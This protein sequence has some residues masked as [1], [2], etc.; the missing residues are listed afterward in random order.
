M[1]GDFQLH[2]GRKREHASHVHSRARG[3]IDTRVRIAKNRRTITHAV[4]NIGIVVQVGHTRAAPLFH[5]NGATFSPE[6]EV[7]SNTQG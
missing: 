1:L 2:L 6:A 3:F 5:I 7:R 4:I